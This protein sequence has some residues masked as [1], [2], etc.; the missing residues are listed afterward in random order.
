MILCNNSM[1]VIFTSNVYYM[2][3]LSISDLHITESLSQIP[4]GNQD[5]L[6]MERKCTNPWR[7]CFIPGG[8]VWLIGISSLDCLISF[9]K[10]SRPAGQ[11]NLKK[12][13]HLPFQRNRLHYVQ[14]F[15]WKLAAIGSY[16]KQL[17][18]GINLS[19]SLDYLVSWVDIGQIGHQKMSVFLSSERVNFVLYQINFPFNEYNA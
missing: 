7:K 13:Y 15:E 17:N 10:A 9:Y 4:P 12:T 5:K 18:Y 6:N 19:E 8:L 1:R 2:K 16:K 3:I 14:A 11:C